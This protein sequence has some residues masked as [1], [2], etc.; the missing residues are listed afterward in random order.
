[1]VNS[2]FFTI[3]FVEKAIRNDEKKY[4]L[5]LLSPCKIVSFQKNYKLTFSY[6]LTGVPNVNIKKD[7]IHIFP[8]IYLSDFILYLFFLFPSCV[9]SQL[10]DSANFILCLRNYISHFS[11]RWLIPEMTTLLAFWSITQKVNPIE[12]YSSPPSSSQTVTY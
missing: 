4:L 5:S 6:F 11:H 12:T 2:K 7:T 1:M 3:P 8:R 10:L 9:S